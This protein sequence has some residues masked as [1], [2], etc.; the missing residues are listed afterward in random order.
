[1]TF[2]DIGNFLGQLGYLGVFLAIFIESG[3]LLGLVLPI[4]GET[5]LIS[6]GALVAAGK[7]NPF[8]LLPVA[9]VAAIA[10]DQVAYYTGKRLGPGLRRRADAQTARLV[11][12]E[13][14]IQAERF[15]EKHGGKSIIIARF[16]PTVR[17]L[18]PVIAG[19]THM[20]YR[21]FVAYNVIGG[22]FW[23]LIAVGVGYAF[24]SSVPAIDKY[25]YPF[26]IILIG[27][28]VLS[29]LFGTAAHQIWTR[30]R[31]PKG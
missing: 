14:I 13:R 8:I 16:V 19:A 10:G 20:P 5:L 28:G 17:I 1:M 23:V 21:R 22:V 27:L 18:T 26:V 29:S 2:P 31:K 30:L 24:G 4:P 7:L 9:M 3:L 15:F 25:I 12:A 11:T 6:T